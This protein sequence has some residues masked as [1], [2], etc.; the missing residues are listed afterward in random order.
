MTTRAETTIRGYGREHQ[1]LRARLAP[2]VATRT[3]ICWRCGKLVASH[4]AWDLGHDDMDRTIIRGPEH[5]GCKRS[6]GARSP[7]RRRRGSSASPQ[8]IPEGAGPGAGSNRRLR[9]AGDFDVYV[10]VAP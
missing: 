8:V 10:R 1:L 6:A 4:H 7:K 3:V 9:V 2:F 5:A